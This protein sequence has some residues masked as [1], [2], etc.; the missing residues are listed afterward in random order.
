MQYIFG[1]LPSRRL[2]FSVGIDI[3][4]YKFCSFNC[5]Y[6][7]LG[8]TTC[9]TRKRAHFFP[10]EG[11][12]NELREFL[13]SSRLQI[14]FLTFSGSGEPTLNSDIGEI[15]GFLKKITDIPVAILTNGSLLYL[16]E[17][18]KNL[19]LADLVIPSLDAV[20]P[21]IFKKINRPV[22]GLEIGR[23]IEGIEKFSRDFKGRIWME[24]VLC[25]GVNDSEDEIKKIAR[26]IEKIKCEKVQLGT[27]A[28][29]PAEPFAQPLAK[30]K[31]T[32]ISRAFG[33][34]IEV[35]GHFQQPP[36]KMNAREE[37][38]IS[39]LNRRPSGIGDLQNVLKISRKE[40]LRILEKLEKKGLIVRVK[41]ERKDYFQRR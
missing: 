10:L 3:I 38:I 26:T 20:T 8:R 31:L 2:G 4:P 37:K 7:E 13:A 22:G 5:I 17:V 18:Q 14:D 36:Q 39:I 23:I 28:R 11:I 16:P 30:D 34:E 9:L 24:V 21:E 35:I 25:E 32:E 29:P 6:C 12:L 27:V 40:L 19:A 41:F 1:P 15:I 33:P